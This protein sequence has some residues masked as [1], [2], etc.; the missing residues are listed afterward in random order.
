MSNINQ[1]AAMPALTQNVQPD[2]ELTSG[3]E[4]DAD[5]PDGNVGTV[6]TRIESVFE[7]VADSVST[8]EELSIVFSSRRSSR[9]SLGQHRVEHVH[10]P[11]RTL[12]EARKFGMADSGGLRFAVPDIFLARVL[13]ILQLSH[14]AL[15]SG[16]I[17]TK[18]HIYYQHQ[19]L[20]EKQTQVD[21]LV[22]DIAFTF[23][24]N[25]SDLNIVGNGKCEVAT[26]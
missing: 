23:G 24:I 18:R 2:D 19:D 5:I 7:S 13:L 17:L 21:D 22:D 26:N 11:G 25:R 3:A 15:V 16:T 14:N 6:I 9:R 4:D 10:F 20:F 8:Q 1:A 12:Q